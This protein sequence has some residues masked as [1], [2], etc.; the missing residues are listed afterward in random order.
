M[1]D[2][3]KALIELGELDAE[4]AE[5][6]REMAK[7][8]AEEAGFIEG[9]ETAE[10]AMKQSEERKTELRMTADRQNLALKEN[11]DKIEVL[12]IKLNGAKSNKEY[13][14][15]RDEQKDIEQANGK[16]E[17]EILGS[18]EEVDTIDAQ[19]TE[20][21]AV[22]DGAKSALAE[23]HADIASRSAT[24][25]ERCKDLD[26]RRADKAE[27][28]DPEDLSNYQRVLENWGDRAVASVDVETGICSACFMRLTKQQLNEVMG[29]RDIIQCQSC[30]RI[31][32][33]GEPVS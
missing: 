27:R 28:V 13:D 33:I 1:I 12:T 16:L 20:R 32:Y 26:A 15:I 5:I 6:R 8:P 31:L 30:R 22:L 14:L 2:D 25:E 21:Q 19:V 9:V 11:E 18:L 24:M 23:K 7:L 4:L 10:A 29:G 17:E 3:L